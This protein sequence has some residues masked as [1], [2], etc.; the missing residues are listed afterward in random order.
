MI[1][2]NCWISHT[3]FLMLYWIQSPMKK[4]LELKLE[5][6]IERFEEIN[7]LLADASIIKDQ[8]QFKAL[9]KEYAQIEP[10]TNCYRDFL[11]A[12]ATL[13]SLDELIKSTDLEIAALAAEE[14][15]EA[16]QCLDALDDALQT[17]LLPK[18]PDDARNIYL[19]V[20]AGTGGDEAALFAGDLFRMYSRYAEKQGWHTEII[21]ASHSEQGGFKEVI[22]RICGHNVY[23][24]LKFESGTHRVQRVPET[25]A[26]GRVHTSAC[27]IA[28]LPEVDEINDVDI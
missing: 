3:I 17:H 6:L 2:R 26:Q 4:S 24:Q 7:R 18:D 20:R 28:I 13:D 11:K 5:Q 23:E 10:I 12:R 21:T 8:H 19:E 22:A 15:H 25:E 9:S 1:V 16:K 14:Q 27:T